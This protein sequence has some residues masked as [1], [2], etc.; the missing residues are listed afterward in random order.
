MMT[1]FNVLA[2]VDVLSETH[3]ELLIESYSSFYQ[4]Q[5]PKHQSKISLTLFSRHYFTYKHKG[6]ALSELGMNLRIVCA[7][8]KEE[9][10]AVFKE[11]SILFLP[12]LEAPGPIVKELLICG[13][14]IL[15]HEESII[16]KHI[17]KQFMLIA[18]KGNDCEYNE[19]HAIEDYADLLEMLYFDP[20]VQKL[21]KKKADKKYRRK[22]NNGGK[23][24]GALTFETV[25]KPIPGGVL[26]IPG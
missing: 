1:T 24:I 19:S 10:T 15:C 11:A 23:L 5:T 13:L 7:T 12:I 26:H 6:M 2:T 21:L 9:T 22:V 25:N 3:L 14:P 16:K 8:T 18:G 20:S 17:E 4:H